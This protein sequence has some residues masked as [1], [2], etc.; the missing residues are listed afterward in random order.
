MSENKKIVVKK[1]EAEAILKKAK[2]TE[3]K[4][5]ETIE[6]HIFKDAKKDSDTFANKAAE[7]AA[8]SALKAVVDANS[9][10]AIR[11]AE[12]A[13]FLEKKNHMLSKCK[14]SKKKTITVPKLY[15]DIIGKF[16]T[17]SYNCIPVTVYPDG[18]PHEYPEFIANKIE[19]KLAKIAASNTYQELIDD[20]T[21]DT[22]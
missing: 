3:P 9:E 10:I 16:Y 4:V 15:A 2:E 12:K 14:N 21:K 19:K 8:Q 1:D 22:F 13:Y 7:A 5:E 6:E 11:E 18:K 17:F 20:R